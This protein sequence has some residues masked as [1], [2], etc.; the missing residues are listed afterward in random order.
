[1]LKIVKTL[2]LAASCFMLTC[3]SVAVAKDKCNDRCNDPCRDLSPKERTCNSSKDHP[4]RYIGVYYRTN[5]PANIG[6]PLDFLNP[7]ITLNANGTAIFYDG[8]SV[9]EFVTEGI[10]TPFYG[11]WQDIGNNQVLITVLG[12]FGA[13]VPDATPPINDYQAIRQTFLLDF[14]QDI[15][16]PLLIAR[17]VVDVTGVPSSEWLTEG[18]GRLITNTFPTPRPLKRICAFSS[19][20]SRT[21]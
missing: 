17:A 3:T 12:F 1:M 19:D 4:S 18:A 15:N 8:L 11:N 9:K 10:Q 14:S 5:I 6:V 20:L 21:Q 2:M 7:L 13:E 16:N